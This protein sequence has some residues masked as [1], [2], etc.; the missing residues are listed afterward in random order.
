[1]PETCLSRRNFNLCLCGAALPALAEAAPESGPWDS[2]AI[3]RK[4]YFT[5]PQPTWPRPD[6]DLKQDVAEIEAKLAELQRKHPGLVKFTGGEVVRVGDDIAAWEKS[7]GGVDAVLAFGLTSGLGPMLPAVRK[8][9]IPML[10]F[11][12]PYAGHT[13]ADV[14]GW[15]QAGKRAEVVASSDYGDLDP[16]MRIF[17]TMHHVRHSKVLIVRPATPGP[18]PGN[19]FTKQFGT[20]IE[21]V[22]YAELRAAFDAADVAKAGQ[23]AREFVDHAV[24]VVEP[25][26]AEIRDAFRLYLAVAEVLRQRKAN[27]M[28]IDCLGGFRRGD[29][30]AYPCV[31]WTKLN[32]Q[33]FYG[34]CEAD[35]ASTMT[36]MVVTSFSGKP[37]FVTDPVFDTSRNE[38]IHAHCVASTAMR[39]V[40][41]Q[42]SP[43]IVRSHLEDNK[44]V[45]LQV[46]MPI[47]ETVTVAKFTE[48]R[49]LLVSTGEVI[50]NVDSPRGCRTQ[51]RTRVADARKFLEGYAGGLH[52]VVFYGDYVQAIERMG[53]LMGFKAVREG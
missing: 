29:L 16:Y 47:A 12:R 40:G 38:V 32:D 21:V 43:Y 17:R 50:S 19:A 42:P 23:A 30:P 34:V 24:R 49:T 37:G 26:P 18:Q 28:A 52:R 46:L 3:V 13:W 36:Q 4:V 20:A 45:S 1:M 35:L 25:G 7:L 6:L 48:P 27:A 51:I 10:L 41:A 44:G 39:G 15:V 33:G 22:P 5:S 8:I 31:A 11:S 2:P 14:A 53:R 9:D